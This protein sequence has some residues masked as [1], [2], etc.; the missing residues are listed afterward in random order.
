MLALLATLV[1]RV[2]FN[3]IRLA[4]TVQ[5]ALAGKIRGRVEVGS[6][7]WPLTHLHTVITGGYLPV[8]VRELKVWDE[9]DEL[10]VDA[11]VASLEID[12]HPAIFGTAY[13]L[14]NVKIDDGGYA[15]I[16]EVKQPYPAHQYD[17]RVVSL[18]SAF[19]PERAPTFRA[20]IVAQSRPL[21][22]LQS[23]EVD[24][25]TLEFRFPDFTAVTKSVS[26]KGFL[27]FDGNDPLAP[28]LFYSLQPSAEK[29]TISTASF[30]LPLSD[31]EVLRLAQVPL[32]WPAE[33]VPRD[34][35]YLARAR[36]PKGMEISI[37]GRML[38][39]WID[40]FG[41]EHRTTLTITRAGSLAEALSDEIATGEDLD[42]RL[43][44][45]GP[46]LAPKLA[47]ELNELDL[48][49][50]LG[51]DRPPLELQV[52][53][54]IAEWDLA[55]HAGS[56]HDTVAHGAGG[57]VHLAANFQLSPLSFDLQV[58]IP[59]AIE[60]GPYLPDPM[61]RLLG[62]Q[63]SGRLY[64][65]GNR[66]IQRLDELDLRLGRA[67]LRG[68]AYRTQTGLIHARSVDVSLGKT[69]IQRLHGEIDTKTRTLDLDFRVVAG[70]ASRWLRYLG[71]P[72]LVRS[73]DGQVHVEGPMAEP[74]AEA[75]LVARGLPIVDR[76]K[77]KL[78]YA[79]RILH[80]Q[81]AVAN[82][83]GG[84]LSG[85][86][87]LEVGS[88]PSL[89]GVRARGRNLALGELPLIGH[90]LS[91]RLEVALAAQGALRRPQID[92]TAKLKGWTVAGE[93]YEDTSLVVE[94]RRDGTRRI[95]AD[96]ER[97]LGGL[98]HV[99]AMADV[100]SSLSGVLSLRKLPLDSLLSYRK[101]GSL[102]GG[103]LSAEMQLGG[104]TFAP[105]LDG[106][107]SLLRGWIHSAFLGTAELSVDPLENGG[108]RI[109]GDIFQ[110][111]ISVDGSVSGSAPYHSDLQLRVRRVELDRFI[112]QIAELFG[113]RGWVSGTLALRGPLIGPR[114]PM[115]YAN[116]TEAEILVKNDDADGRPA[117][118]RVRNRTPLKLAYDGTTLRFLEEA[119][120]RGPTGDFSVSGSGSESALDFRFAGSVAVEFLQPYMRQHF[121]SMT[122]TLDIE[123][124]A[125]GPLVAPRIVGVLEIDGVQLKPTGQDAVV[126][127]PAGKVDFSND[128]LSLTGL[129]LVVVDEYSD[130]RAELSIAGGVRLNNF[131]PDMWA[132]RVDGK[133]AGKMLLV[134]APQV[135][136][137]ASG[138]ANVSVA[139]LG[140]GTT[141]NIDGTIEFNPSA[142]LAF[143]PR[144]AR[145]ELLLKG[146][147]IRFTDRLV[148]LERL[149]GVVDDEGVLA[150]VSGEI[151]LE[152]W[153]PVDVDLSVTARDL[154]FR[155]PRELELALN[156][157]DLQ[158]VGGIDGG[159]EIN[160]Q[161]EVV[162]G[163]Y[164]R[165]WNP[166]LD[167]LRPVRSTESAPP[168]YAGIPLLRD[169]RL[170]LF[171]L[172]RSFDVA[173]NVANIELNGDV[174]ITGTP[175][176]PR[177]DGVI[178]VEEGSFKFQ[179]MA[180][181]FENTSGS[182]RFSPFSRFPEDTPVLSLES[183]SNYR[184][185]DG[186]NH[187]VLLSLN[188][189]LSKLDWD[190]R[191]SAGLN[192]A[193]TLSLIFAR[194]TPDDARQAFLGDAPVG[195]P[196]EFKGSGSTAPSDNTLQ[197]LDQFAKD[198]A[199]DWFSLI[200]EDRLRAVTKL[201]VARLQIGTAS[202]GFK[203]RK[204]WTRSFRTIFDVER[205]LRGWNVDARS[206]Y[207]LND[208]ISVDGEVLRQEFDDDADENRT[209]VRA[210]MTW[211][212][213]IP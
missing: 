52:A 26:G 183:E 149:R 175:A 154:Q 27:T 179:G 168:F 98:L 160:G 138:T 117:P 139:L 14:R 96:I 192:R 145:R 148:E 71:A 62:G 85:E 184:D 170:D 35:E 38:D 129:S 63:L 115:L 137:A 57:E 156:L 81:K 87:S 130:E 84:V 60:V 78:R 58:E 140:P 113:V 110:G 202:I 125:T 21:I 111:K 135:F 141:P 122:G 197:A 28:K 29:A 152:N 76:V 105:T 61:V 43:D 2:F 194:R 36:G 171:L 208:E 159:L 116:L 153:Q 70:D 48:H 108:V 196:G 12:V 5:S 178:Y 206:E 80:V 4:D 186:Q 1:A 46:V 191:T 77:T 23:Y 190:L 37:E 18:L 198:F 182:V 173:N 195:R 65:F 143:T 161:I 188:G 185:M 19:Y 204:D 127:V 177:F 128:Q 10:V 3:G 68:Q 151:S 93:G 54:A 147:A 200:I 146:G 31:L 72:P 86:G 212:Y 50:P 118:I 94:S 176:R 133:L 142:P 213:L 95:V 132:M 97:K 8:E 134:L 42:L 39:H 24:D 201:D 25:L 189:P 56:V 109:T 136:S 166:V 90:L 69:R 53:Q 22:E 172:A 44:I 30:E 73:V 103:V 89:R 210:K 187:L 99:D 32:R 82:A 102:M 13:S 181:Q 79:K 41:G 157:Y 88:R 59:K 34:L 49:L 144:A 47:A 131:E 155:V 106:E 162:H 119:I 16:K 174:A 64:A 165:E 211:R 150:D 207:R 104:T 15:L 209:Q 66:E 205:S 112:P 74:T 51:R 123:A 167:A 40:I 45:E 158:V 67:H 20:G 55:T 33:T 164:V 91:G 6:I 126:S 203:G 163:R 7:D 121:E 11:P 114:R 169:A 124:R 92:A 180:A 107:V 193:Q 75:S 120:V 9:F 83:L 199:G 17:K 100:E 101:D